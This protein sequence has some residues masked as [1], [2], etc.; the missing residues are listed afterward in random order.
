MG[1]QDVVLLPPN[2]PSYFFTTFLTFVVEVKALMLSHVL[3]L[4]LGVGKDMLSVK[5]FCSNKSSFVSFEFHGGYKTVTNVE[6]D[7]ATLSL[8]DITRFKAVVFVSVSEM[9]HSL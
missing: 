1:F 9:D 2:P 3:G 6:V 7:L 5:Y 8:G 4:W